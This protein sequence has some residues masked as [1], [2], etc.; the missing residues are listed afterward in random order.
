MKNKLIAKKNSN[1]FSE[2]YVNTLEIKSELL[3]TCTLE[4]IYHKKYVINHNSYLRF[5][6]M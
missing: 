6:A 5:H 4:I 3:N 2:Y 1:N